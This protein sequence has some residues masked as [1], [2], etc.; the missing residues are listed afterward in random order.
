MTLGKLINM[1]AVLDALKD[2]KAAIPN[3]FTHYK[4]YNVVNL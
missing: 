1:F 4:R 2:M 3:D